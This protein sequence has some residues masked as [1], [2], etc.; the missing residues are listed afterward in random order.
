MAKTL[1]VLA[2]KNFKIT[3]PD[4]AKVTFGPWSP[5]PKGRE[6]ERGEK[7]GTLRIYQ[8]TKEN[9][10]ACFSGVQGFRD[11]SMNYAEEVAR[12][13]GAT[14][15]KDDGKGYVR[16]DKLSIKRDWVTPQLEAPTIRR[17][18]KR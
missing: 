17:K 15:W 14:I 10:L 1:L 12:E 5:P 8:G 2:E 9:I 7:V 4:D 11:L 3:I 6:W 18:A 13:E 16:E